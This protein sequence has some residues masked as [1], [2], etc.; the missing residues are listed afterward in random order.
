[1]RSPRSTPP[2]R[3]VGLPRAARRGTT[4]AQG[5]R[6]LHLGAP[7]LNHAVDITATI[8]VKLAALRAHDSQLGERFAELEQLLRT[9][10]AELSVPT[11]WPVPNYSTA[12]RTGRTPQRRKG[13]PNN[14][15]LFTT[16][17]RRFHENKRTAA[18]GAQ[19]IA[20]SRCA[21]RR[22]SRRR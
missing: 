11:R 19:P 17:H 2:R 16:A 9:R 7:E 20:G 12:P 13:R 21:P 1:M 10:A 22:R 5:A 15:R 14:Q 3:T 8:D 18:S 4:A 6:G